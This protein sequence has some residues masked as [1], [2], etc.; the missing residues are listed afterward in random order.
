MSQNRPD[1]LAVLASKFYR[2]RKNE[3]PPGKL[4][5]FRTPVYH[6][7]E[8]R[9]ITHFD[10]NFLIRAPRLDGVPPISLEQWEALDALEYYSNLFALR[11]VLQKGD[12][13]FVF[14]HSTLH[15]R[16]KYRDSPELHRHLLRLWISTPDCF[17]LPQ[18]L[19]EELKFVFI[20]IFVITIFY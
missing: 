14:N 2:D 13:Q 17:P 9:V 18:I 6:L 10:R 15:S 7:H 5:F 16:E 12:M 20:M 8:G 19:R 1:L 3:I 11:M 4:P